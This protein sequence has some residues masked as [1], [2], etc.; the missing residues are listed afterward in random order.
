[1]GYW[2]RPTTA[3]I[4]IRAFAKNRNELLREMTIG[5]Q[6][7]V[8]EGKQDINSLTRKTGRW[9]VFHDGSFEILIVK[10]LDEILYRSEVYNEFLVDCQP[11]IK[12]DR[13]EAEVSFV[14]KSFVKL[15]LEIKATTTHEFTF[16]EVA[17]GETIPSIWEDIP[18]FD[19]PGWY[20]DVV[21]DI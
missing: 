4:G 1:M 20:G 19:G 18:S 3:D 16:R 14:E 12:S 6:S 8:L 9:E 13:I 5:M 2:V 17:S 21:F 11:I 10:W 7:I 15:E